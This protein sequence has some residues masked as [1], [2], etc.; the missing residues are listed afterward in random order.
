M[1]L[2]SA[3]VERGFCARCGTPLFY[4]GV[5][6]PHI[7]FC[8]GALDEPQRFPPKRQVGMEGLMPWF[9]TLAGLPDT[10]T[11]EAEM[12]EEAASIAATNHQHPDHDTANWPQGDA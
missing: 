8:T 7:N 6:S 4:N 2:S 9:D 1:F 12:P 3:E 5:T 10:G 11:T